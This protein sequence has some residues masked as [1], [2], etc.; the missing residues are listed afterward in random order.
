MP[1]FLMSKG[2]IMQKCKFFMEHLRVTQAY[3]VYHD[4]TPDHTSYS[5]TGSFALDLGGRDTGRDWA[6]AP[7]DIV[8]KRIYG[9]YNAVWFETL[10]EVMCADRVARH[11]VF[12]MLHI[13]TPILETLG[14]QVGKVFRQGERFYCEGTA[15]ATGNHIHMEVGIAPYIPTGWSRTPLRDMSGNYVWKIN[16]QLKPHEIFIVGD[17]VNIIDSGGYDWVRESD[18]DNDTNVPCKKCEELKAVISRMETDAALAK[19]KIKQAGEQIQADDFYIKKLKQGKEELQE[20]LGKMTVENGTLKET[21]ISLQ[22]QLEEARQPVKEN[23]FFLKL[24]NILFGG[25]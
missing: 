7:C 11:L 8:V 13:D 24:L 19:E 18:F 23:G 1:S 5:H 16:K 25:A 4:C 3:G 17:D 12:L 6:Y 14:I 2:E 20:K 10:E 22:E 21:I 15:G 9:K